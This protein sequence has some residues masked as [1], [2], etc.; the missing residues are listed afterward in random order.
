MK[1]I[2]N[3]KICKKKIKPKSV[4]KGQINFYC[5]KKCLYQGRKGATPWNIGIKAK[6]DERI[7]RFVEAGRKAR[8]G[9][10]NWNTGLTWGH[11]GWI[12]KYDPNRYRNIHKK[13]Y[14]L[15]GSPNKCEVCGKTGNNRQ[16]HWANKSG[17]Y[18][19]TL[20]DWLRL[21]VPCHKNYDL[22]RN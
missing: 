12:R 19:R 8:I 7:K 6:D 5:S 22:N 1:N 17:E 10:P 16:I 2:R 15:Y 4:H 3:C 18:K 21:C 13:I 14:K 11:S 20:D 9:L